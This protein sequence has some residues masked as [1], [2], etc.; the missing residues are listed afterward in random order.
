MWVALPRPLSSRSPDPQC[1]YPERPLGCARSQQLAPP[2]PTAME[3]SLPSSP[4]CPPWPHLILAVELLVGNVGGQVRVQESTEGQPVVPAA[5]KVGDVDILQEKKKH[6]SN[7]HRGLLRR[8][9]RGAEAPRPSRLSLCRKHGRLGGWGPGSGPAGVSDQ[10]PP[11]TPDRCN[12][13]SR[14]LSHPNPGLGGHSPGGWGL[15]LWGSGEQ[16]CCVRKSC[17]P[18]SSPTF[19]GHHK[20]CTLRTSCQPALHAND[21]GAGWGSHSAS[22]RTTSTL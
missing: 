19:A 10:P 18:A 6:V 20:P 17:G 12:H 2:P 13:S 16:Q 11:C 7:T 1:R 15:R 5:A 9:P 22:P 3:G 21:V 8:W 14:N 4:A